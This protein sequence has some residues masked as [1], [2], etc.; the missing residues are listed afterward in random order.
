MKTY[1]VILTCLLLS[2]TF[3]AANIQA[4]TAY[5]GGNLVINA[6]S[7][8][9]SNAAMITTIT[10]DL[11]I[12]ADLAPFPQFPALKVVEGNLT[13][14][15]LDGDVFFSSLRSTPSALGALTRI[16]GESYS[17]EIIESS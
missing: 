8:V 13:I 14:S 17:S 5:T 16:G 6:D 2:N 7:D 4:Q 1:L 11:T 9:P 12:H 3:F 15:N 10:G